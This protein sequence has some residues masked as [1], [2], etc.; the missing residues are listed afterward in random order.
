MDSRKLSLKKYAA[1]IAILIVLVMTVL[2]VTLVNVALP[3][4]ADK[5]GISDSY[6][7]WIVTIYQLAITMLLLPLS[8]VGDLFSY[9]RNFLIG[10]A[11]FTFSSALCAASTS[12]S[13]ILISR[14]FQGI[15]AACVMSVNIA[16]TRIIYP[17]N[18]LGRGLALNA[19]VIAIATAAGP[20]IA[21]CILSV[22][23]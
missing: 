6:S 10:V 8:S 4:M 22:A 16:L 5:F 19:M 21:G 23:S 12:F 2:D 20:T 17:R 9:R 1:V 15:G 7:V 13:M 14:A 3:V 18:I 11:V